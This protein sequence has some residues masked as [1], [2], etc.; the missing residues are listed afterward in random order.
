M[1]TISVIPADRVRGLRLMMN[2]DE[3]RTRMAAWPPRASILHGVGVCAP[4]DPEALGTWVAAAD[5]GLAWAV[6]NIHPPAGLM[7]RATTASRGDIIP[8]LVSAAD[9]DEA[10]AGFRSLPL[11]SCP[12]F[13]L[14]VASAQELAVLEWDGRHR[15]T[16]C[17][18][19]TQ[20][21]LFASSSLGDALV[22]EPRQ[23]LFETLLARESDAWRAQDRLHVHAWPDRRHL[24]VLMSRPTACTVS[25]TAV[26]VDDC[27]VEMSYAPMVDGWP[28]PV[29]RAGVARAAARLAVPA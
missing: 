19:L 14:I 18:R 3:R 1:C 27:R 10:A 4:T 6:M 23:A 2:R 9:L 29:S 11:A 7:P 21:R 22:E 13:R 28:G 5:T 12:P 26:V 25:R 17:E 16:R 15:R 8:A 24:S 20:P